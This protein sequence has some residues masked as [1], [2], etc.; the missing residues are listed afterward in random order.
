[1]VAE[2]PFSRINWVDVLAVILL[3]RMGYI[4]LRLGLGAELV[5]LVGLIAGFV[6]GFR[7]YQ[8]VGDFLARRTFLSTEWVSMLTM[9]LI[10]AVV[11][12]VV[13]RIMRLLEKL[14]QINFEKKLNQVG[15]LVAGL[16]RGLLIASV[17]LV[18]CQQ[19]SAPTLQESI[20]QHSMSGRM[21]SQVAPAVYDRLRELPRR[22]LAKLSSK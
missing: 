4:G 15:G 10:V 22:M 17:A 21:V 20:Q 2:T 11:Y 13:T 12:F 18:A 6:V 5:K 14:V 9:V 1:M 7:Y 19:L 3:V 16:V 8:E